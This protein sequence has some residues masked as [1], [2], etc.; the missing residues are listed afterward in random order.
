MLKEEI[1]WSKLGKELIEG[2]KCILNKEVEKYYY[3]KVYIYLEEIEGNYSL[4]EEFR[5]K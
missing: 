4:K 5:G 2:Y 3:G 1:R